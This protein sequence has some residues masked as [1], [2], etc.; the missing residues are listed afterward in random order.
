MSSLTGGD[1]LWLIRA[2]EM[3]SGVV[4]DLSSTDFGLFFKDYG[5]DIFGDRYNFHGNSKAR[6][7]RAFWD[8][9]PDELV[10]PVLVDLL[11]STGTFER[12]SEEI[13]NG[14][15]TLEKL[16]GMLPRESYPGMLPGRNKEANTKGEVR[17]LDQLWGA[18]P[19]RVFISHIG[20]HKSDAMKIQQSLA[21]LGIVSFVAHSD[22]EPS[23]EWQT[24]IE[25]ALH[26]MNLFVALLTKGYKESDWT[27]QEVGF[28]LARE[29]PVLPVSRGLLP[30]GFVAKIQALKWS[31]S[32]ADPIAIRVMK[33]ALESDEL[34]S[35]AKDSFIAAVSRAPGSW[36]SN[37]SKV[38]SLMKSLTTDQ[39]DSF[40][41]AFNSNSQVQ[42]AIA[43]K[44]EIAGQLMGLTGLIYIVDESGKISIV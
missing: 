1:K 6:R 37:L 16:K 22:I 34:N 30:Y 33:M 41:R 24:E 35:L 23:K 7:L 25:N 9:E 27:D 32:S 10:G 20:N 29:V 40:V 11:N 13:G 14:R 31:E 28:A 21:H 19:I 38:L 18:S 3:E 5:V 2:L 42:E 12:D 17:Q 36:A 43:C 39:A 4:L 44:I 26:S 15:A 8:I